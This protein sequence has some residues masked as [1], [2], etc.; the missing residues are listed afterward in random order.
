MP[1]LEDFE[2]P[3]L[4]E[5]LS[6]HTLTLT[7]LFRIHKGLISDAEYIRCK[8]TVQL[9]LHELDKRR[10]RMIN[11]SPPLGVPIVQI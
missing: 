9:I 11:E 5:M 4:I 1:K 2:T 10:G 6:E 7:T 3:V 8:E